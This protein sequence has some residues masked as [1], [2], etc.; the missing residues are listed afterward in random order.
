M[1]TFILFILLIL[2]SY[3]YPQSLLTLEAYC[4]L[5]EENNIELQQAEWQ[6]RAATHERKVS[7]TASLPHIDII[8]EGTANLNHL[9]AW[10]APQGSYHPYTYQ[11]LASLTWPIYQGGSITAQ[12][13]MARAN[14]TIQSLNLQSTRHQLRYQSQLCYWQAASAQALLQAAQAYQAIILQQQNLV[15]QR[16]NQGAIGRT[17]LLLINT[18]SHEAQLQ[19]IQAEEHLTLCLAQLNSLMNQPPHTPIDSLQSIYSPLPPFA[20]L[21]LQASLPLRPDYQSSH[22]AIRHRQAAR[23]QALS[24]YLPQLS[25]FF[26]SGWD[27]GT[28]YM[29]TDVAHTPII[30]AT[31]NI[32]LV[33]W[34]AAIQ[35]N[36]REK[37]LVA[38]Q[39]LAHS[40]LLLDL[41]LQHS[42]A[43]I[44]LR[45]TTR[46]VQTA[47]Q[48]MQLAH[49]NLQLITLS[50]HEG[51]SSMNDVLA[52]QLS[53]TTAQTALIQAHLAQKLAVA[54]YKLSTNQ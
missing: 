28:S 24:Q 20:H 33:R 12:K 48:T 27:T 31:I 11:A 21:S 3:A 19:L 25:L 7:E 13:Q 46:Q 47:R 44:R 4:A 8:L 10:H 39:Q 26:A 5:V 45:E 23:K 37:A 14:E 16:F 30:G 2:S 29:G 34:G 43:T 42:E 15:Q 54:H 6:S 22:F 35:A 18:R 38:I 40:N 41:T 32:P 36:R 50:Y 1:K 52:A 9:D 49:E 53:W 51:R 17:D